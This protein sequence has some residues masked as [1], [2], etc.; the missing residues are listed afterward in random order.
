MFFGDYPEKYIREEE[1]AIAILPV[2]YDG[3]STWVK[4]A[5]KAP[6]AILE[7][8]VQLEWYDEETGAEVF[9]KGIFTDQPLDGFSSPE[10]MVGETKNKVGKLLDKRFFIV[11]LG[12]EHSISIGAIAAFQERYRD[13][14]VLQID[15]HAD[16][17]ESY[18]GSKY[19]HACVMAR[20]RE[21]CPIVQVGIRALDKSE[22]EKMDISRVFWGKD[23]HGRTAWFDDAISKL[24]QNV[25]IT[26]DV[27]GFDPSVFPSTG[28]PVPGGLDWY[29]G[30]Q[31]L[32][33]VSEQRNI[34]G[35][36][37]VE[38]CPDP[39]RK[40]SDFAAAQLIYKLLG[41]VFMNR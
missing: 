3:T 35:F 2:P 12:G 22:R 24:G 16:L 25:Y 37:L 18:M 26:I 13:F 28:T 41:Y 8:S 20:A 5:D 36:D 14:S 15:A 33:R 19:N 1:A 30:L 23:I 29:Q 38:L 6:G 11:S 40:A 31:F 21:L 17:R 34:V 4:G 7:A 9:R 10:G 39:A 27:D 32:K